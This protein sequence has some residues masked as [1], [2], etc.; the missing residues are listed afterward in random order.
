M[1]RFS[2]PIGV[3]LVLASAIAF[4][5]PPLQKQGS[6]QPIAA[7]GVT[8]DARALEMKADTRVQGHI[9][10][11]VPGTVYQVVVSSDGN[12]TTDIAGAT[13]SLT[14]NAAG[15]INFNQLLVGTNISDVNSIRV[16]DPA[17]TELA[18]TEQLL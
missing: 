13:F 2:F 5:A 8:G 15:K 4:A 14:A 10:N 18:C 16:V 7:S 3:A 11:L 9:D 12:C 6:F 1:R 17:G